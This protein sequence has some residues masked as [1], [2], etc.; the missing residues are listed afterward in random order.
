MPAMDAAP[1]IDHHLRAIG[2][3]H[4]NHVFEREAVPDFH[5]LLGR[6]D[7]AGIGSSRE[8]LTHA[9]M[10]SRREQL[11]GA[12]YAER[13]ALFG[14]DGVLPALAAGDGEERDIGIK[15]AR[16]VSEQA[17]PFVIGMRG[18]EEDTRGDARFVDGFDGVCEGLR[19]SDVSARR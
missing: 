18:D 16:E 4:A 1:A 13:A 3:D 17:R 19:A 6:L 8:K 5:G 14:A 7:V 15:A 12:D 10:F 2:A 11:F 9:V